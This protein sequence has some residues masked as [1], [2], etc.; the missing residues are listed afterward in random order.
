MAGAL[1]L[2]FDGPVFPTKAFLFPENNRPLSL[3]VCSRLKL[4]PYVEYWR[5]DPIA[6][7]MLN[8]LLTI[9]SYDLVISSSWADDWLHEKSQ[10][11]A[12]LNEN[13]LEYNLHRQW[14]TPRDKHDSREEQIADWLDKNPEYREKYIILDDVSSGAGLADKKGVA[15]LGLDKNNIFLVDIHE[16][17]SYKDYQKIAAIMRTW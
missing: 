10:I 6:I 17:L 5:A 13:N 2:D 12:L 7:A 16:G 11:E 9:Y 15:K 8:R 3:E 14:R 4:H 1:F